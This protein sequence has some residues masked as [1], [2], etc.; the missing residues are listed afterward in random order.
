LGG[1]PPICKVVKRPPYMDGPNRSPRSPVVEALQLY[2]GSIFLAAGAFV[3]TTLAF[4]I[5]ITY[6]VAYGTSVTGLHLARSTML[7]AVLMGQVVNL[8]ALFI[9]GALSD[10]YGRRRIS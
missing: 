6:L 5:F 2:R 7:A 9:A 3:S 10:R 1:G 8:P 4:Y